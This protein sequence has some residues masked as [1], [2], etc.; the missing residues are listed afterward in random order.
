MLFRSGPIDQA[1]RVA[2]LLP[3]LQPTLLSVG[4]GA[5]GS[6]QAR[7]HPVVSG[8][9]QALTGWLGA[10]RLTLERNNPI[11]LDLCTRCNA[12]IVACP[13]QAIGLDYQIDLTRCLNHRA[14]VQACGTLAAIDFE[15][16]PETE[17]LTFDLVLDL[18]STP[19]LPQHALPQGYLA[20]ARQDVLDCVSTLRGLVGEFEKPRFFQ[21]KQKLCAHTRNEQIGCRACIDICSAEAIQ[22]DPQQIGRAH[23]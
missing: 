2:E 11:D 9:I 17:T 22:T 19:V 23:V 7:A 18:Q 3:D 8:R 12:C 20:T 6:S 21:Y 5:T 16:R 13:E 14:C 4:A 15:R 10:F 1:Q